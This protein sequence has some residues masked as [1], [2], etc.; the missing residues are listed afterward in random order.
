LLSDAGKSIAN[1]EI[2][3]DDFFRKFLQARPKYALPTY[4]VSAA[5]S[6]QAELPVYYKQVGRVKVP[7][8][9]D[10]RTKLPLTS[11]SIYWININNEELLSDELEDTPMESDGQ[12]VSASSMESEEFDTFTEK[13]ILSVKKET[14]P[15]ANTA[16]TSVKQLEDVYGMT[17]SDKSY[18]RGGIADISEDDATIE[19]LTEPKCL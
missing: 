5:E 8:L 12:E 13:S 1:D 10:G 17:F 4:R 14:A 3:M 18:G 2:D 15:K 6:G 9:P 16:K 11:N 19:D 7:H